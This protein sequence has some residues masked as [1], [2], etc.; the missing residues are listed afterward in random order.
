MS[1]SSK[2]VTILE[3]MAYEFKKGL[4]LITATHSKLPI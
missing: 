1:T 4:V 3:S 2:T